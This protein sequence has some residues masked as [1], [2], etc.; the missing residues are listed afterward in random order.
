MK[1]QVLLYQRYME[2]LLEENASDTDWKEVLKTHMD[3]ILFFQH[4][5]SIHLMVT[6]AFAV[7][8]FLSIGFASVSDNIMM[9]VLCIAVL[10]LLVPYIM[11]YYF[12]ENEVQKMYLTYDEIQKRIR[13][14][15][16]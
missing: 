7:F 11:H 16:K 13:K 9:L 1:K 15:Q 3:K 2:K 5:R 14:D 12:L 8:E 4:E 6:L 10:I